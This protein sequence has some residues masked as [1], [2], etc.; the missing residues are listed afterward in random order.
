MLVRKRIAPAADRCSI[1]LDGLAAARPSTGSRKVRVPGEA[2]SKR[3][4]AGYAE[5]RLPGERR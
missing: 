3:T 2:A 5:H 1:P 4:N